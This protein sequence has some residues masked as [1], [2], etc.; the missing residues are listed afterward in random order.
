M[1][2]KN[3]QLIVT[4]IEYSICINIYFLYCL[5]T[6]LINKIVQQFLFAQILSIP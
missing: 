4:D 5:E 2:W 1:P 3:A 6:F